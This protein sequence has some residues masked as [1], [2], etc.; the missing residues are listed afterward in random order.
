MTKCDIF[1]MKKTKKTYDCFQFRTVCD[2][3]S[4]KNNLGLY[5]KLPYCNYIDRIVKL[6]NITCFFLK[7]K[8]S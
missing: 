1:D 7:F 6:T 4:A 5:C 2:R 3:L 8:T